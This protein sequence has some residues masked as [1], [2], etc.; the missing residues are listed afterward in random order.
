MD[1][2]KAMYKKVLNLMLAFIRSKN[3]V[4]AAIR[5]EIFTNENVNS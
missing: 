4:A 2:D 1:K 3:G 5:K